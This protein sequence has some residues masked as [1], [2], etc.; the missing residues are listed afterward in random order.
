M[1]AVYAHGLI[2]EIGLLAQSSLGSEKPHIRWELLEPAGASA[3]LVSKSNFLKPCQSSCPFFGFLPKAN[4][5]HCA[6][7]VV[8]GDLAG[9]FRQGRQLW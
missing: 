7:T 6:P 9:A 5:S 2:W 8:H 1:L 4:N 3:G